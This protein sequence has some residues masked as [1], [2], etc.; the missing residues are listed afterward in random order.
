MQKVGTVNFFVEKPQ[1]VPEATGSAISLS[2]GVYAGECFGGAVCGWNTD[3][4][5][6]TVRVAAEDPVW[7]VARVFTDLCVTVSV[8]LRRVASRCRALIRRSL[9][10]RVKPKAAVLASCL[11]MRR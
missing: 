11:R 2:G 5:A 10:R 6:L 9:R 3:G 8:M 7:A 1:I 4:T